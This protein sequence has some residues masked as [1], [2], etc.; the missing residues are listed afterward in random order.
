MSARKTSKGPTTS[1]QGR[2]VSWGS[3]NGPRRD[4]RPIRLDDGPA[5]RRVLFQRRVSVYGQGGP[6]PSRFRQ[7]PYLR[8]LRYA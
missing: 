2:I 3:S 8:S 4:E 1:G 6:G 5:L 7:R